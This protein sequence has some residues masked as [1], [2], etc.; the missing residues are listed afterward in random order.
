M[1]CLRIRGAILESRLVGSAA[2]EGQWDGD[3][4]EGEGVIMNASVSNLRGRHFGTY[5]RYYEGLCPLINFVDLDSHHTS[6]LESIEARGDALV[7]VVV[8]DNGVV[9][10]LTRREFGRPKKSKYLITSSRIECKDPCSSTTLN[11]AGRSA[12]SSG[13]ISKQHVMINS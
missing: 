1:G 13:P 10:A 3:G 4:D 5:W 6:I 7:T 2:E 9:V 11:G 12:Q 8:A